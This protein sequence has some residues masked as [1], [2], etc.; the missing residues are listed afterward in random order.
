[1]MPLVVG[2]LGGLYVNQ[3]SACGQF[4]EVMILERF[5]QLRNL[6]KLRQKERPCASRE[7]ERN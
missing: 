7:T 3:Q 2:G 1:M 6:R 4:Y 5:D